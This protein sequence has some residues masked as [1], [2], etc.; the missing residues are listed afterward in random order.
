MTNKEAIAYL[1]TKIIEAKKAY[2]SG[3]P[4]MNDMTYDKLEQELKKLDEYHPVNY[5]VGYS[6]DY[7]WWI[8]HYRSD[9]MESYKKSSQYY[10]A[11]AVYELL[12]EVICYDGIFDVSHEAGKNAWLENEDLTSEQMMRKTLNLL[13]DKLAHKIKWREQQNK[14]DN[15]E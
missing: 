13:A 12:E 6:E 3:K 4:I 14:L 2:Y 8:K 5:L 1:A 15:G 9:I 10:A 11:N 7:D